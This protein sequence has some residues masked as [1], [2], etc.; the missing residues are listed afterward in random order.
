MK[1]AERWRLIKPD[2]TDGPVVLVPEGTYTEEAARRYFSR[3]FPRL[4]RRGSGWTVRF[5]GMSPV[6]EDLDGRGAGSR[7]LGRRG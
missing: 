1:R 2:G 4:T 7:T 3:A 6:L 5:E